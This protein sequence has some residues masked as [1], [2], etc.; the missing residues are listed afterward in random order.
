MQKRAKVLKTHSKK[1]DYV[2]LGNARPFPE[3]SSSIATC[4]V[5]IIQ[6]GKGLVRGYA[7][8]RLT[9]V[10]HDMALLGLDLELSFNILHVQ[11]NRYQK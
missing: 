4:G 1:T 5:G 9:R 11:C 2:F 7:L 10:F 6:R 8:Y 3:Q